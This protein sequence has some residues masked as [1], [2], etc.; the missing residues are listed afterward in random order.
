M[1]SNRYNL[2]LGICLFLL[3]IILFLGWGVLRK[4]RLDSASQQMVITTLR[5][6]FSADNAQFLAEN[7]HPSYLRQMSAE[8]INNYIS[9]T[10]R[11]L[12]PLTSIDAIRGSSDASMNALSGG[13]INSNYEV[14]LVFADSEATVQTTLK[15]ES[16]NWLF[17]SFVILSERLVE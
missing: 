3:I 6:I 14:D 8:S 9:S 12:G 13:D 11:I 15:V 10:Q 2:L 17:T 16:G 5:T 4:S 7:A 1:K